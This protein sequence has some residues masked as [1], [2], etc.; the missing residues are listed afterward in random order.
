[1]G[2]RFRNSGL[3]VHQQRGRCEKVFWPELAI[4]TLPCEPRAL[5]PG[6]GSVAV[7]GGTTATMRT[8]NRASLTSRRAIHETSSSRVFVYSRCYTSTNLPKCLSFCSTFVSLVLLTSGCT[9]SVCRI[10]VQFWQIVVPKRY[11]FLVLL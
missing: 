7:D 11:F 9:P 10:S 2:C 8:S 3:A 1:M 4:G 5:A 6:S